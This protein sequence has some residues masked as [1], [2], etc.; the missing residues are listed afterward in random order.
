MLEY[1]SSVL[2]YWS[3][4][5]YYNT[6]VLLKYYSRSKNCQFFCLQTLPLCELSPIADHPRLSGEKIPSAESFTEPSLS[7]PEG[8]W[9]Q[10]EVTTLSISIILSIA[11]L[12]LVTFLLLRRKK[13]YEYSK[14]IFAL[15]I[16]YNL[17][18]FIFF[19]GKVKQLNVFLQRIHV[20]K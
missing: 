19:V 10:T 2:Y 15:H 1:C 18:F 16:F 4:T 13:S 6:R 11:I 9:T 3:I 8:L 5:H 12:L 7:C 20:Y 14:F 17:L